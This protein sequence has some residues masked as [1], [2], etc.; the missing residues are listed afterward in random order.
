[1][2]N[3]MNLV[4]GSTG[5][6]GSEICRLLAAAGKPVKALV[7]AS[8]DKAKVEKLKA[9]GANVVQADL[10]EAAS[11]KAACKGVSAVIVTASSMPF[12][13][14]PGVN[15]P[16]NTDQAGMLSLVAAAKEA[17]VQ[18]F[19]YTS[20]PPMGAIFPLQDAKRAVEASLRTSGMIYTILHPTFFNEVWLNPAAGFDYA[21]HKA[22]IYGNGENPI[23]WISFLDVAQFA[24]ACV[25]NPAA[26]NVTL[27]LG[28][29]AGISPL[30]VVKIFEKV[31]GKPF[32][33]SHVPVEAL[34]AQLAGT[35]DPFQ[36]SFAGLMIGYAGA[37]A[38]DMQA[39]LKA[40]P[41][42]LSSVEDYAKSVY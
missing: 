30:G 37:T 38:I 36:K 25:D 27:P 41:L 17:G 28:G 11:L 1:M 39:T 18:Q 7:R 19:V 2:E 42:K 13:Y 34:Q 4:I 26:R 24:A 12:C 16:Q 29:P 5:M 9:L 32:E 22:A 21:N 15:S 6:V 35:D 40:F 23:S 3:K 8:S 31:G 20:F 14:Q 10:R 33:V